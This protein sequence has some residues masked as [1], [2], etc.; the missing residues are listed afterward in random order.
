MEETDLFEF[1]FNIYPNAPLFVIGVV[2]EMVGIPIW[3]LRKLDEMGVVRPHR[4]G[5]R[6]RCYSK[7]QIKQL[8]RIRYLMQQK[9][10]NISG[11]KVILEMKYREEDDHV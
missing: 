3:T 1:D 9:R 8:F 2:S 4:I 7:E 11:I 10:V 5:N 6:T